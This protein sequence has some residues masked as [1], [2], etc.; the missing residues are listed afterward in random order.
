MTGKAYCAHCNAAMI[1]DGGTSHT[2]QK[3][4]YYICKGRKKGVCEK[5]RD[6]K[7]YQKKLIDNVVTKVFVG[8][9]FTIV[10]MNLANASDVEEIRLAK[11]KT[12]LEH[13]FSV[14][15]LSRLAQK[16]G[17]EPALRFPVLLP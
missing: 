9:G 13:I 12:A 16:A 15:A 14:Q 4:Q 1:S 7:D 11:I 10:H 5:R 3:Q 2:G 6:D 8:D 17:F